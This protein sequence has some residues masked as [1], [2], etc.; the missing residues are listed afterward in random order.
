MT[1]QVIGRRAA[2]IGKN[3]YAA[4]GIRRGYGVTYPV[5]VLAERLRIDIG[6]HFD[7]RHRRVTLTEDVFGDIEQL[8]SQ[9]PVGY[10][11]DA[12]RHARSR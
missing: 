10:Q 3:Q 1:G 12:Y 7:P 6:R 4:P 5:G 2:D 9:L 11:Y 8:C